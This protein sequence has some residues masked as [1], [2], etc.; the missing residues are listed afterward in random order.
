MTAS[1]GGGFIFDID[2]LILP[3]SSDNGIKVDKVNPTFP[4]QDIIGYIVPKTSGAGKPIFGTFR[5]NINGW[6]FTTDDIIDLFYHI[7]HDYKAGTDIFVHVHW[8]HNGTAISGD[9][10]FTHFSTYAK[11]HDQSDFPAEITNTIT[12]DTV[13]IAT[14]PQF[15]H[16][17]NEIQL[18]SS[19][20][21]ASL[22]NSDDLEPDGMVFMRLKTTTIPAITAGS[23]FIHTIDIHY[24]STN[25]GS[26][27]NTPDFYS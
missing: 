4:W 23:L 10:V 5:G 26:K 20:G 15:N 2:D 24:Q 7:P 25:I 6:Q 21:S 13:N 22:L 27:N 8:G 9:V 17:L 3:K 11:G 18:S 1:G 19:G 14:T 12:V 16:R